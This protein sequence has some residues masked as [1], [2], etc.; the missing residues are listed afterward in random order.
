MLNKFKFDYDFKED[1]LFVFDESRK[2]K[3]SIEF[4]DLVVD[5]EKTWNIVGLEIFNASEYLSELTNKK[6]TKEALKEIEGAVMDFT[7]KKGTTIIKLI[8]PIKKEKI[9]A[10]IAIQNMNYRSPVTA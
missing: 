8:L 7:V 4:G 9:P 5:L 1:L 2:S 10:T 6:I 3:G